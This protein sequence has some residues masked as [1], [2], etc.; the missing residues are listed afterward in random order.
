MFICA[1]LLSFASAA[2]Q[3]PYRVLEPQRWRSPSDLVFAEPALTLPLYKGKSS[4]PSQKFLRAIA[5]PKSNQTSVFSDALEA[6][7][8]TCSLTICFRLPTVEREEVRGHLLTT[9]SAYTTLITFGD[10]TFTTIV[11]TGSA[12][13]WVVENNF[14]CKSLD[15][16]YVN[17]HLT[18]NCGQAIAGHS[19]W[20][21]LHSTAIWR[22]IEA[23]IARL[24]L[25][26]S[27]NRSFGM[28]IWYY[29]HAW[30]HFQANL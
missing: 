7:L 17:W 29:V 19:R 25:K 28:R 1:A 13:T 3:A 26:Q 21:S 2:Q 4:S 16:G 20:H 14:T 24:T 27:F 10:Q 12:D 30:R 8:S 9:S 5:S 23:R 15:T 18:S 6:S 22:P 11:D